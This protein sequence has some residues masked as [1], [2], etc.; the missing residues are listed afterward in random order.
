M[1]LPK[2]TDRCWSALIQSCR[3]FPIWV[4]AHVPAPEHIGDLELIDQ[5]V[6]EGNVDVAVDAEDID[7]LG[8]QAKSSMLALTS[9]E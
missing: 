7:K 2:H 9:C 5:D 1:L 3:R 8:M 6:V 4:Y